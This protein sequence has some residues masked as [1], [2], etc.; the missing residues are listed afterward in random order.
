MK[1]LPLQQYTR[2]EGYFNMASSLPSFFV[3][4]DLGP[5][6]YNAYGECEFVQWPLDTSNRLWHSAIL[7]RWSASMQVGFHVLIFCRV[8]EQF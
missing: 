4:P 3:K 2:R 6:M 5:K 7:E 8:L 1:A